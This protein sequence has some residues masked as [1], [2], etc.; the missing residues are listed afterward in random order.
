MEIAHGRPRTP[1]GVA[2]LLVIALP[3]VVSHAC[4]TTM[5]FVDR[6]FLA[7]LGP[8]YMSASMAGG[9]T[10][11]TFMT[12]FLGLI[13][14]SNALVA[15]NLGAGRKDRCAVAATQALIVAVCAYPIVLACI[16]LGEFMFRATGIAPEQLAPQLEYFR[17]LMFGTVLGLLRS[18]VSSFF[19]GVGRTRPVMVSAAIAMVVNIGMN[20]VLIFGKLG[21]PALG[22][23]GAAIGTL[24]GSFAALVVLGIV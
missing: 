15:Q 18:A 11:F 5:M 24:C 9:L 19:C 21:F 10:C 4:E 16:P 12:F 7:Q 17:I 20:W 2:E 23:K 6:L 14:Y 13:G 3:M 22:I 1:G 8:Q